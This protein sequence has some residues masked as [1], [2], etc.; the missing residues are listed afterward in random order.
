[1]HRWHT[2]DQASLTG[3]KDFR[4]GRVFMNR[5][6]ATD[7]NRCGLPGLGSALQLALP[8]VTLGLRRSSAFNRR[9]L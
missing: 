9:R 2:S 6:R 7:R 8:G 3:T 4:R 5:Q 1:M